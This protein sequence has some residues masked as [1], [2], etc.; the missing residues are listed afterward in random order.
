VGNWCRFTRPHVP[1]SRYG[2]FWWVDFR[3]RRRHRTFCVPRHANA[4]RTGSAKAQSAKHTALPVSAMAR[5]YARLHAATRGRQGDTP[6][7]SAVRPKP[8]PGIPAAART[9]MHGTV[10]SSVDPN[11]AAGMRQVSTRPDGRGSTPPMEKQPHA[12][13]ASDAGFAR[14]NTDA[15]LKSH[16]AQAP[17]GNSVASNSQRPTRLMG[18]PGL[19]P[20]RTTHTR[21]TVNSERTTPHYANTGTSCDEYRRACSHGATLGRDERYRGADW[22]ASKRVRAQIGSRAIRKADGSGSKRRSGAVGNV[23]RAAASLELDNLRSLANTCGFAGPFGQCDQ[24]ARRACH[25]FELPERKGLLGKGL[26]MPSTIETGC[27]G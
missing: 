14:T 19:G 15:G 2:P 25:A 1:R 12:S 23:L 11:A 9:D 6:A 4:W 13:G 20:R 17:G 7:A 16:T 22:R 24:S 3:A 5:D 27:G 18:D 8:S 10:F 21:T 26:A